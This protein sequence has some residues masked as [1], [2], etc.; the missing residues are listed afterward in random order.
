MISKEEKLTDRIVNLETYI[1]NI[2]VFVHDQ[3]G[4]DIYDYC[5]EPEKEQLEAKKIALKIR[6][7]I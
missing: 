4:I 3:T 1:D 7:V 2:W 5:L 6:G